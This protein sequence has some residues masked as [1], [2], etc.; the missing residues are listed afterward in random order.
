MAITA[1]LIQ[2]S[3]VSFG[4]DAI[5]LPDD[6][7]DVEANSCGLFTASSVEPSF[8]TCVKENFDPAGFARRGAVDKGANPPRL[9]GREHH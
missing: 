1:T 4:L 7:R 8:G 9:E 3:D 6:G 2:D 5:E